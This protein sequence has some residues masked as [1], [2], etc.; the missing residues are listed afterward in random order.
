MSSKL[1]NVP[2]SFEELL[3]ETFHNYYETSFNIVTEIFAED[4]DFDRCMVG[5]LK[6][7]SCVGEHMHASLNQR[8][9]PRNERLLAVVSLSFGVG[10][11]NCSQGKC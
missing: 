9:T 7:S 10:E 8:L 11:T 6:H 3:F 4:L 1:A 2:H 5:L